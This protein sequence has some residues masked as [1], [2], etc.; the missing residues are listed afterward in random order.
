MQYLHILLS[1]FLLSL[2]LVTIFMLGYSVYKR[3][4]PGA[5]AFSMLCLSLLFYAFGYS[6]ELFSTQLPQMIT[7]NYFQFIGIPFIPAFWLVIAIQYTGNDRL[8]YPLTY[9]SVF[10]LP[11]ITLI[12]RFTN[13]FHQL[14]Y[15]S[16]S[17]RDNGIFQVMHLEKGPFHYV[18]IAFVLACILIANYLYLDFYRK[19][20]GVF[21]KQSLIMLLS[22]ILPLIA[23]ALL[24]FD[25]A[26][27]DLD[28]TP[29]AI[30]LSSVFFMVVIFKYRFLNLRPFVQ[31]LIFENTNDGIVILD[32][33]NVLVDYNTK[34]NDILK[35]VARE[36]VGEEI[37]A[38]LKEHE[39]LVKSILHH[40]KDYK[41]NVAVDGAVRHFNIA[42]N[43]IRDRKGRE[44][45][46][47]VTLTDNTKQ[48]EIIEM[49][50]RMATVD[51]LTGIYNRRYFF[52]RCLYE[53]K[54]G[55]RFKHKAAF[56]IADIDFFKAVNDEYGH[57]AGDLVLQT[58]TGIFRKSIRDIDI[59]GR[60]GGEEFVLFLPETGMEGAV[61]LAERIMK[62]ISETATIFDSKAIRV[63][64]SFGVSGTGC[65]TDDDIDV[66]LKN[67]DNALYM[68]KNEGRKCVRALPMDL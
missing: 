63:T 17:L 46:H 35:N 47:L 31:N 55:K 36:S 38:I 20:K 10:M 2:S 57:Q 60:F 62:T 11:V 51:D 19:A 16:M 65:V 54:R 44:M 8:P 22:S 45:G 64:A 15:T 9:F 48:I 41:F 3:N 14:F 4:F 18:H 33:N 37:S 59:L 13:N 26:P 24:I 58:V 7:W 40:E 67:A 42:T 21:K 52:E 5:G 61:I 53:L 30:I 27:F 49:L 28:Y 50:N 32:K 1:G 66:F 29:L 6:M 68:A 43:S 56:I 34:A 39:D 12:V 23:F 25:I